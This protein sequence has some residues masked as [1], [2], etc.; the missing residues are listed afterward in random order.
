M[1]P[2][3][4]LIVAI[5]GPAGSGKSTVAKLAAQRLQ[6][7]YIDTGAMYR[8]VTV[9]VMRQGLDPAD[10]TA[11]E[12]VAR[13]S[14]IEFVPGKTGRVLLNGEDVSEAIRSP[15]V[16]RLVSAHVASYPGVRQVLVAAQRAMGAHGGVVMEGRDITT[17]VFPQ[18]QVKIFMLAS[19]ESRA[20][21]RFEELR[22]KGKPQA[23]A[24]LLADLQKRDAEDARR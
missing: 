13:A 18:A 7:T 10:Q 9:A 3:P 17:V 19:Q 2:K 5:D 12:Q 24:E 22:L 4:K 14:H 16:S 8:A 1:S 15:E 21:R 23:Y 6:Y 11:V 20:L